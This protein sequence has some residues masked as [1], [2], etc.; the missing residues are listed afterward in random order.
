M[1]RVSHIHRRTSEIMVR[2]VKCQLLTSDIDN[3]CHR[4]AA[5]CRL[6]PSIDALVLAR[7]LHTLSRRPSTGVTRHGI[8]LR[9][10]ICAL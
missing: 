1:W 4:T 6:R 9:Y 10:F 3:P 2:D 7:S 5:N 8:I